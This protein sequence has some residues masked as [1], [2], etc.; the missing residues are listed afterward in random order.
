MHDLKRA[1]FRA[2]AVQRYIENREKAVL[3]RFVTPRT[4]LCLWLLLGLLVA[5]GVVA[6]LTPIPIYASG[7]AIV[8]ASHDDSESMRDEVLVVAFV[9]PE[10]LPHLQVGQRLF[11]H[12]DSVGER[13]SNSVGV[14]E[15]QI[16]SPATARQRFAPDG[17]ATLV[18]PQPAA[19]V[20]T[21]LKALPGDMP[22]AIYSGTTG[23]VDVEV[24]SRR[25]LSLVP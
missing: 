1:I 20:M 9:P 14:V 3:P 22:T 7:P 15:P 8:V 18:V 13:L 11:L 10:H 12:F 19:V 16:I 25:M 6:W 23:H 21:R 4:F 24:G 2:E 5:G 17:C